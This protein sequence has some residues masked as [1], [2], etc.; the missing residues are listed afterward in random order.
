MRSSAIPDT[1]RYFMIYF[2][3]FFACILLVLTALSFEDT[4][5]Q[6]RS[7][8]SMYLGSAAASIASVTD[9]NYISTFSPG[10]ENSDRYVKLLDVLRTTRERY[11]NINKILVL[12]KTVPGMHTWLTATGG[13]LAVTPSARPIPGARQISPLS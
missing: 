7:S 4:K 8:T 5:T 12:E 3:V 9:W 1:L 6:I 13:R 10:N 11:P 2:I